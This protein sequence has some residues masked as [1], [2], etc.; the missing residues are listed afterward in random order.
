MAP[1]PHRPL[2][3]SNMSCH[4]FG[5]SMAITWVALVRL[6]SNLEKAHTQVPSNIAGKFQLDRTSGYRETAVADT[7]TDVRACSV[8]P[9]VCGRTCKKKQ[10]KT[11]KPRARN[12]N[13]TGRCS[14]SRGRTCK[15]K[16]KN[17]KLSNHT[18]CSFALACPYMRSRKC[19]AVRAKK[20]K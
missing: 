10:K 11:F 20:I 7:H 9:Y 5:K 16:N 2:L 8:C 14:L 19:V 12:N 15:P 6:I 18:V 4:W 17:K 13:H 3:R 1:F